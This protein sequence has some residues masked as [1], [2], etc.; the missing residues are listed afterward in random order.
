MALVLVSEAPSATNEN[1]ANVHGGRKKRVKKSLKGE[2]M[3][4]SIW[5]P[6]SC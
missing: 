4:Y 6:G 1:E 5:I 3:I 2:D